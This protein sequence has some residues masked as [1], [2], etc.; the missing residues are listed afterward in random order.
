MK[1]PTKASWT[2]L[3]R[4]ALYLAGTQSARVVLMKP[5][6]DYDPHEAFL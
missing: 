3:Q 6:T 1:Q 4:L 2:R 5:G